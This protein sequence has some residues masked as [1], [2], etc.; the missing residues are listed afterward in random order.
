MIYRERESF[1]LHRK[2]TPKKSLKKKTFPPYFLYCFSGHQK[3]K[4]TKN[5]CKKS[6]SQASAVQTLP[7]LPRRVDVHHLWTTLCKST[8]VRCGKNQGKMW[9]F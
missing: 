4:H 1:P 5:G 9:K 3:K 2:I 6:R 8:T 7:D